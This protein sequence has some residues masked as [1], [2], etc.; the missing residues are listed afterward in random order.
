MKIDSERTTYLNDLKNLRKNMT[1][2]N[3]LI[4]GVIGEPPYAETLGDRNIPY[5]QN[6]TENATNTGCLY[7]SAMNPYVSST[8][9]KTLNVDYVNF[10][11][12][13]IDS[14]RTADAKIPLVTVMLSGRPMIINNP[15]NVSTAFISAWLPGTSGGQG[16]VDAIVG[17]YLIRP[18]G[19][20]DKANSLSMDWP[21]NMD[22]LKNFP[23]YYPDGVLPRIPNPLFEVGYGLSTG[24]SS[25][26]E[27]E[28]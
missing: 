25:A 9:D 21:A 28:A 14:V 19:K 2:R 22:S 18:N 3:T 27:M 26:E 24:T 17:D 20:V 4:I 11:T 5:C 13:V 23:I 15:L 8:Q 12:E 16:I 10:D 1:A 7:D 6:V